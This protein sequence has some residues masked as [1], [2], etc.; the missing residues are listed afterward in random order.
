V[1]GAPQAAALQNQPFHMITHHTTSPTWPRFG[2]LCR[3]TAQKGIAYLLEALRLYRDRHG[4]V[5]FTFAGT[6]DLEET[7][8]AFAV[9]HRLEH[10]RVAPVDNPA[11]ILSEVDV[12]VHPSIGDAMPM[13]IAEALMCGKPCVV[14]RVGGCADLVRDE[15]EGF[16]IEPGRTDLILAAME[17]F[18]AMPEER[19]SEMCRAAR[20]RYDERCRPDMVGDQVERVYRKIVERGR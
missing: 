2:V 3:L 8:R 9:E 10:V 18:R 16:V 11:R 19:Y 14:C 4:D 12:F 7:I 1:S 6:G 20:S 5:R 17:R 15:I 13:A